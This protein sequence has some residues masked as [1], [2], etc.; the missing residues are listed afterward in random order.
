MTRTIVLPRSSRIGIHTAILL[1]W[2]QRFM[3]VVGLWIVHVLRLCLVVPQHFE[4]VQ[5]ALT[6]R[7]HD[8]EEFLLVLYDDF[9]AQDLRGE[10]VGQTGWGRG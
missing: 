5:F 7:I 10:R 2:S 4:G 1:L 3:L 6:L 8:E 9:Q